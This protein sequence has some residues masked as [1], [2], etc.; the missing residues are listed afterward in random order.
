MTREQALLNLRARAPLAE[1]ER[2]ARAIVADVGMAPEEVDQE[3]HYRLLYWAKD[4][5]T[6]DELRALGLVR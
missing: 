5:A 6:P 1:L 3:R 2:Q 4:N